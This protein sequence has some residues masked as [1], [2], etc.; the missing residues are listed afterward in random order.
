[1]KKKPKQ[2]H[3]LIIHTFVNPE[4]L[5][6]YN[7]FLNDYKYHNVFERKKKKKWY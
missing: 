5:S 4:D 2:Q 6:V 7:Q 3:F 1:M